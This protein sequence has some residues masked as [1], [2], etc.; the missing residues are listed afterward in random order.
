MLVSAP[1]PKQSF[2]KFAMARAP[3][4]APEA[5]ALPGMNPTCVAGGTR[6]NLASASNRL[7]MVEAVAWREAFR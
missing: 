7:V 2:T 6:E 3:W 4:P 1:S 5:G